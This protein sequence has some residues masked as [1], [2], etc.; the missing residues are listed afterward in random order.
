MIEF[1]FVFDC[2]TMEKVLQF[3]KVV[4][5]DTATNWKTVPTVLGVISGDGEVVVNG[6]EK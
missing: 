1:R 4:N 3:R 2:E 5:K 6:D